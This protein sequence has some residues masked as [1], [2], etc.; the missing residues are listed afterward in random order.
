MNR[1]LA[2]GFVALCSIMWIAEAADM[3]PWML[4]KGKAVIQGNSS[5]TVTDEWPARKA[6]LL[7]IEDSRPP[8]EYQRCEEAERLDLPVK[9]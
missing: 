2:A 9:P 8:I 4:K 1:C 7:K 6:R 3:Q 5:G